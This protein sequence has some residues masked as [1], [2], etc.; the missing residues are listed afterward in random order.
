MAWLLA[1]AEPKKWGFGENKLSIA[2][3]RCYHIVVWK[4]S[5]PREFC[6]ATGHFSD[7]SITDDQISAD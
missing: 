4:S 6:N 1:R 5:N 2:V 3:F 7:K